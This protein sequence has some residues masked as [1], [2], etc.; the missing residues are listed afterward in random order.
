MLFVMVLSLSSCREKIAA[1]ELAS[2]VKNTNDQCPVRTQFGEL[3]SV[4]Y[5]KDKNEVVFDCKVDTKQLDCDFEVLRKYSKIWRENVLI[6][7]GDPALQSIIKDIVAAN[8]S[9]SIN[10]KDTSSKSALSAHFSAD[11]LKTSLEE[12]LSPKERSRRLLDF[13]IL[14]SKARCPLVADEY[15]TL[16]DVNDEG[17]NVVYSYTVD[18]SSV[19]MALVQENIDEFKKNMIRELRT[20]PVERQTAA[21]I[22][23]N[24]KG[25]IYSYKG[26]RTGTVVEVPVTVAELPR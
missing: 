25:V 2:K 7:F 11:E 23:E 5:D 1:N 3:S 17:D 24:G 20:N 26:D 15:T 13:N 22:R 19:D 16:V 12:S 6:Q 4:R 10:Y 14:I 18:E 9:M 21:L 8:A